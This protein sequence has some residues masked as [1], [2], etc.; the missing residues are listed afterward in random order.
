MDSVWMVVTFDYIIR[1]IFAT[2][3]EARDYI[4]S[5]EPDI[6]NIRI[7]GMMEFR[8]GDILRHYGNARTV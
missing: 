2:E 3:A 7:M 1:A 6:V 4:R 8:V 5:H